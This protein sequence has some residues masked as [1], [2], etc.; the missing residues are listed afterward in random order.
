LA[1][2]S[3]K[4]QQRS[5]LNAWLKELLFLVVFQALAISKKVK[6]YYKVFVNNFEKSFHSKKFQMK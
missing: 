1:F 3:Y 5:S 6:N 2:T 4:K